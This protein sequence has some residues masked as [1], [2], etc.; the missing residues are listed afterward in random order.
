MATL[1]IGFG[2]REALRTVAITA[3]TFLVLGTVSALW[4][5]PL[6]MRMTPTTGFEIALLVAQ[7]V[8]AG[9]YL[10]VSGPACAAKAAGAGGVL[11][12][13]GV[14][15]PVCNKLLVLA[16]GPTLLLEYFEPIRLYVGVAGVAL[17]GYALWRKFSGHACAPAPVET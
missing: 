10:G 14:A 17:L 11:G 16:F 5:N 3:A 15:C 6:F 7:S 8:L 1:S 9:L 12:F 13:L 2:G 4:A